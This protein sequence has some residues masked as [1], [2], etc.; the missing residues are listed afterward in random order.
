M[1]SCLKTRFFHPSSVLAREQSPP[2]QT[3]LSPFGSGRQ[4]Q[5]RVWE[6]CAVLSLPIGRVGSGN[7]YKPVERIA[8]VTT[9]T[10]SAP[11]HL[12][13]SRDFAFLGGLE[14]SY[15]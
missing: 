4:S 8:S 6:N 11:N 13:K 7:R 1:G 3:A 14:I 10:S 15:V 2:A 12:L 5:E 9:T